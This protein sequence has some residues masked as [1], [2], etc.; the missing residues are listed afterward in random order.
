MKPWSYTLPSR[1][2]SSFRRLSVDLSVCVAG[3][4]GALEFHDNIITKLIPSAGIPRVA[5]N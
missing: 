2:V 1:H 3:V 4:G 5:G